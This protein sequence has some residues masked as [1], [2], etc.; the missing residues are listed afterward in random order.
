MGSNIFS[1]GF[2]VSCSRVKG[3]LLNVKGPYHFISLVS[4]T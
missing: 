4:L 2:I 1:F 3:Q